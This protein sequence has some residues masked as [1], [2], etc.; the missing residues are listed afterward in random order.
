MSFQ[1]ELRRNM[2]YAGEYSQLGNGLTNAELRS[3]AAQLMA[4]IQDGLISS[5]KN[6]EHKFTAGQSV[7]S[8]IHPISQRFIRKQRMDNGNQIS[9]NSKRGLFR[10]RS[11]VYRVWYSFQVDPKKEEE[12]IT[13]RQA[14]NGF[15]A[16]DGIRLDYILYDQRTNKEYPF[17]T[18]IDGFQ[19]ERDFVLAVKASIRITDEQQRHSK[20]HI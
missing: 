8:Y 19:F 7:V 20:E 16:K 13:L 15:A 14:L 12:F 18:Q 6:S 11:L 9:A 2:R 5:A 4:V 3:E 1:D 17:P 10:D